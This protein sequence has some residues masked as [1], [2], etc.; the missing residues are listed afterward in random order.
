MRT[1][2]KLAQ[3]GGAAL[4]FFALAGMTD[5]VLADTVTLTPVKDNTLFQSTTGNLSSGAGESLFVGR[6]DRSD[7]YLRRALL[8]YDYS[9]IPAGS[10]I[11]GVSLTLRM[12][13]TRADSADPVSV[14]RASASWGEA[15]SNS[16]QAG[17]GQGAPAQGGDATWLHRFYSSTL[18]STPGGDFAAAASATINVGTSNGDYAWSSA[19]LV[20]DV[21]GWV[22]NP[23]T[24]NGWLLKGL[25][26]S[27]KTARRFVSRE[28]SNASQRPRLAVTFTPPAN[29]GACC[30]PD[31][32]CIVATQSA[33]T[34]QGGVYQGTN[35]SC[36]PNPCAVATGACCFGNGTCQVLT[37][38]ACAAGS[39]VYQGDLTACTPGSCPIVLA[40][41][42]DPLPIPAVAQPVNGQP[43]QAADYMM[44]AREF[45]QQLH[46]DLP[47][48]L[49]WGFSSTQAGP[50]SYPGPTILARRDQPVTVTWINDLRE[51][52]TGQLRSQHYLPVDTCLHGPNTL[53]A[54]ARIVTHLHG[55]HVPFD[56]DGYPEEII[57]PGQ[58]SAP[59]FYPNAQPPGTL[60]Y[61][62]HA[63]GITRLNVIMGL[64]GFYL[65]SDSFEEGLGL[66]SGEFERGLAIQDRSF[67]PDGT[68][69]Y[70]ASWE[71]D[72]YGD[73]AL[74]NGKVWPYLNVRRALYRFRLL[75]GSTS[76]TYTLSLSN[77]AP[78]HVI[79]TD[80]GL[81]PAPVQRTQV[82]IASGE[83]LDVVMDFRSY[84]AGTE[85]V[86]SNS[87]PSPGPALPNVMK[88][89]VLGDTG[90]PPS[91][92]STLRPVPAIPASE[93]SLEREFILARTADPCTGTVW[94]INGHHWD[95]ISEFP[96]LGTT[97]I[98]S[99]I[100]PSSMMHPMHMHLV[101]FQVLDRQN[102]EMVGGQVVPIGS[103]TPPPP[104]EAG[105]K[106]TVRSQPGQITRVIARFEDYLGKF[107]YHCHILE[108]EDHEMMR[109]FQ[110]TCYAN[111][112]MS[113]TA[114]V[115][116][117]ADFT[118]F[119][120]QFA[121]GNPYANCDRSTVAP[122]LNVADFTC[123]LQ[124]F[125]AGCQ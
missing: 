55:G 60:W 57:L 54:S 119:L 79:G 16:T 110:T 73:F 17:G 1:A 32:T 105:W 31:T 74:V 94:L 44:Y 53:G 66:P 103:R 35:S 87:E 62:D 91:L 89:V 50:A 10:T 28:E 106:D 118:C 100:N 68:F 85:I 36:T 96:R 38:A 77:G 95:H 13:R 116:N 98:W 29:T 109:Q 115:L 92:P 93:A 61:H 12:D 124:Q 64:A 20:A 24:N 40:P 4:L 67:N 111:C 5:T 117:V 69:R 37:Q 65:L 86:L 14:H 76:R 22:N 15:G 47:P 45:Q 102:F 39:G 63:L 21:Q 122:V 88:F 49:V 30:L 51:L 75:N 42:V 112:D 27:S 114:P 113:Q 52:A 107:P 26:T 71:P 123:F 58:Q 23:A 8:A 7:N 70:P 82:T 18:W 81:L 80:L 3:R 19:G 34:S 99:F 120:Q 97:E 11:T 41:F 84:T 43:G 59:Y 83:R 9:S 108:H 56:S 46:R 78:F 121:A 2:T 6:T 72:F 90:G 33:C 25:E 104:E 125:A 101:A 48:T